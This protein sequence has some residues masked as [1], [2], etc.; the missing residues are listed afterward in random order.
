MSDTTVPADVELPAYVYDLARIRHAHRRLRA[1]LPAP[2]HL[3]YSVK[4]N[5]HPL[6]IGEL[7]RLGCAAEISSPGELDAAL[8]GGI[9]ADRMLYTGPGKRDAD[10]IG[11]VK[12]GVRWFSV[13]SPAELARVNGVAEALGAAVTCLLRINAAQPLSGQGLAMAGA[14]SPFGADQEWVS[15]DPAV[16]RPGVAG[17]H[18]YL[19]SNL[20]DEDALTAQ[21][22]QALGSAQRLAGALGVPMRVLDLGGGFGAPFARAGE[23][24]RFPA[25]VGR[26]TATLDRTFP[27]WRSGRPALVFESGR[28]LTGECGTLF[29]RVLDVKESHGR[30]V[31]ILESGVHHLGG[32]SGLRRLPQI[33][34]DLIGPDPAAPDEFAGA[35]VAGPLC[36]PLDTWASSARLPRLR[37]GDVVRVPNVGA[38]GLTASLLA[39][40][41]HPAPREVI[42]DGGTVVDVSQLS[43]VRRPAGPYQPRGREI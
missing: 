37:A 9:A 26:L 17:L 42:I 27:Q 23:P 19:G 8:S 4:A 43:V 29:C 33:M 34:P 7:G 20:D 13:D 2:S 25:L 1:A 41:G 6:V 16:F 15:T 38:Y 12:S 5:P 18:Y 3:L 28:Y 40:L 22:D 35:V 39:F 24:T 36:T 31:V 10:V 14:A 21:F 30:P 32:M 11:A